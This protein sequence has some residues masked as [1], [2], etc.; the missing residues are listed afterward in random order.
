MGRDIYSFVQSELLDKSTLQ[1]K[2]SDYLVGKS[3][4]GLPLRTRSKVL[5]SYVCEALNY[6][7]PSNFLKTKP[8]FPCQQF[9][10]YTQKSNNLQI[11]ND[12]ISADRRYVLVRINEEDFITQIK[13]IDG[14][15]LKALDT[16][17]KLTTKY[18]ARV[19]QSFLGERYTDDAPE[20]KPFVKEKVNDVAFSPSSDPDSDSLMSIKALYTKLS[21]LIG[22]R[23]KT[24]NLVQER[25]TAD[26]AHEL[27]C[28]CLGYAVFTDDGQ[29]PDIPNQLLEVK[30]QMSPTIDL[31]L[32]K[33]DSNE[34]T[35]F[36]LSNV[37]IKIS[38]CRYLVLTAHRINE[39]EVEIDDLFI[40]SGLD[41]FSIFTLFGG[42]VQNAKLQIPLPSNFWD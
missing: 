34:L 31:G 25:T 9:D 42:K 3:L 5:K 28:R 13:V 20:L 17:G 23:I 15:G 26:D 12:E 2:L 41:F 39:Y 16:T 14:E 6:D 24:D 36:R 22:K 4:A 37:N 11:W 30:L 18:Q 40:T 33:P 21:S 8:K 29:F 35:A 19:P 32:H 10:V 7:I 38:M 27:V 1:K